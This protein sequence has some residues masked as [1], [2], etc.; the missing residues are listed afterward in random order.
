MNLP[1]VDHRNMAGLLT[2]FG[3]K[4]P[5]YPMIDCNQAAIT[6]DSRFC[7]ISTAW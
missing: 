4:T 7:W 3:R 1:R 2:T 5:A 6:L